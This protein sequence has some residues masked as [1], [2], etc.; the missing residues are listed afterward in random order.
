[1]EIATRLAWSMPVRPDLLGESLQAFDES[2]PTLL[3]LR[4]CHSYGRGPQ[5]FVTRLPSEVVALIEHEIF[6][7]RRTKIREEVDEDLMPENP[8]IELFS[9]FESRC[10]PVDHMD[11]VMSGYLDAALDNISPCSICLRHDD[12]CYSDYCVEGCRQ[13]YDDAVNDILLDSDYISYRHWDNCGMWK[14][15]IDPEEG[16]ARY[17]QVLRKFFG[18]DMW[19]AHTRLDEEHAHKDAKRA[20]SIWWTADTLRT[21]ICYIFLPNDLPK[22][23]V[24]CREQNIEH[25]D[26]METVSTQVVPLAD[27]KSIIEEARLGRFRKVLKVLDLEPHVQRYQKEASDGSAKRSPSVESG[28]DM[29]EEQV[30]PQLLM[31]TSGVVHGDT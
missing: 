16:S 31:L 28:T 29:N 18:L 5:A 12:W 24:L 8:W 2:L 27:L 9:C 25:G 17:V 15:R 23:H 22:P 10:Q 1:M 30:W 13:L 26:E 20:H 19:V 3:M 11:D 6:I 14:T 4:L 21:T 7:A